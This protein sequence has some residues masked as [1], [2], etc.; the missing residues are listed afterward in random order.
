M[1]NLVKKFWELKCAPDVMACVGK[2]HKQDKEISEAMSMVPYVNRFVRK[3]KTKYP[4]DQT[5]HS[6]FVCWK[7]SNRRFD[8]S[9]IR[10]Y[11][12]CLRH[13]RKPVKTSPRAFYIPKTFRKRS[14]ISRTKNR[15]I[16]IRTPVQRIGMGYYA[17]FLCKES[18]K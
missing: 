10:L 11:G 1:P 6:R 5:C 15:S 13:T 2:I 8:G 3:F 17:F 18:I 9:F 4:N 7:L 12:L 14:Q 16:Y